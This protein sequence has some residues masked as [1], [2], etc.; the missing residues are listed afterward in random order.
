[1]TSETEAQL[2]ARCRQ[3]DAQAWDALFDAHYAAAG[4]FVFQL[5]P[6]FSAEDVEEI[7]Q[8]AF[9]AVIKNINSFTG[10]S[11]LQTW[12]FRI[13]ANKSRDYRERNQAA[14]RGGGQTH[15]PPSIGK[16]R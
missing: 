13:A 8:E 14:K 3:G 12:I 2:V 15:P 7:C 4:R 1:M 6:A 9:L 11:R 5:S 16:L 10:A